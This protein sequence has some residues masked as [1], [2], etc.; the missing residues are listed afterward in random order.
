MT[1]TKPKA[2][3]EDRIEALVCSCGCREL[4]LLPDGSPDISSR[5]FFSSDCRTRAKTLKNAVARARREK[6]NRLLDHKVEKRCTACSRKCGAAKA[7]E[8]E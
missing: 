6:F 4:L 8:T 3:P 2:K 7:S 1:A 5:R